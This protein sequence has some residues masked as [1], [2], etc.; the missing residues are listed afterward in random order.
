MTGESRGQ[1]GGDRRGLLIGWAMILVVAAADAVL[2]LT[3]DFTL[4]WASELPVLVCASVLGMVCLIYGSMRKVPRIAQLA[5]TAL[6]LVLYTNAAAILSYLLVDLLHGPL[7]D[8]QLADADRVLGFDWLAAYHWWKSSHWWSV[9]RWIY[10]SLGPE[11]VLLLLILGAAGQSARAYELYLAF[12]ISSLAV[13]LLGGLLPAA[14][15]FVEYHVAEAGT[16]RYVQQYLGL[17]DGTIRAID[18]RAM[19]G[20]VQFPSFHAALAVLCGYVLRG[21]RGFLPATIVNG[22]IVVVTPVI[23][24]HHLID[25]IGGLLLAVVTIGCLSMIRRL[26]AASAIG[27]GAY[28]LDI[29][30]PCG[31][32]A[33]RRR[34]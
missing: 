17:R 28:T 3:S 27:P 9:S 20:I 21:F 4:S 24:G 15:A 29:P 34:S 8:H 18:L 19:Q 31:E 13:I 5:G 14:G 25:V 10:Y 16:S 30:G 2:L 26:P 33:P 32:S 22:L 11:L 7:L 12:A 23:G 1:A 6:M